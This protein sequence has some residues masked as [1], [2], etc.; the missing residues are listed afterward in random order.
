VI[1]EIPTSSF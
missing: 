1:E